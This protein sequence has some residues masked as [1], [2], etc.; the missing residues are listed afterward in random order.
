MPIDRLPVTFTEVCFA[1]DT[2]LKPVHQT[3][4]RDSM[5]GRELFESFLPVIDSIHVDSRQ[6]PR[7]LSFSGL[8]CTVIL[9]RRIDSERVKQI[10]NN[11]YGHLRCVK[12]VRY[13]FT[14]G[15]NLSVKEAAEQ[16]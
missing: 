4:E 14:K 13:P 9:A 7:N 11:V 12:N 16:G 1:S 10:V 15:V 8:L 5:I 2:P 3:V 6:V